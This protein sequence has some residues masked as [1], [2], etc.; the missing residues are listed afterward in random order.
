M[1]IG[2]FGVIGMI[3]SGTT[4]EDLERRDMEWKSEMEKRKGV[5]VQIEY[6]PKELVDACERY[7]DQKE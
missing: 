5:G 1:K 6:A 4:L 7:Y 2:L 3:I